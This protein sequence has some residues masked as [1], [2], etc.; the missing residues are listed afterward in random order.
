MS[1]VVGACTTPS[2]TIAAIDTD[3]VAVPSIPIPPMTSIVIDADAIGSTRCSE[4]NDPA[5]FFYGQLAMA[6]LDELASVPPP[7]IERQ[8]ILLGSLFVSGYFGGIYLR[9]ALSGHGDSPIPSPVL[10]LVGRATAVAVE[11]TAADLLAASHSD[12]A[13]VSARSRQLAPL[14]AAT[15]GYN[16]GYVEVALA[17]PPVGVVPDP[18]SIVCSDLFECRTAALPLP[19]LDRLDRGRLAVTPEL[20]AAGSDAISSGRAV[21]EL[22]LSG[23][24]FSPVAYSAILDLSGGFLQGI[25]AALWATAAGRTDGAVGQAGLSV[26]AGIVVWA[27]SYFI[28]LSSPLAD[29][30]RPTLIG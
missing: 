24:G 12:D 2:G 5:R 17:H 3:R 22:I 13:T 19:A 26:A 27:G 11:A 14:L 23:S 8:R 30:A 28:G 16:R 29:D 4:C 20:R 25:E 21:W 15:A 7:T 18:A 1:L 9:G 10:D 6:A